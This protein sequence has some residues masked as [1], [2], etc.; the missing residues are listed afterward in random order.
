MAS[1][2]VV[3]DEGS[4]CVVDGGSQ[5]NTERYARDEAQLEL[6]RAV[7]RGDLAT[8]Q[9]TLERGASVSLMDRFGQC[10]FVIVFSITMYVVVVC[11]QH[12]TTHCC[13]VGT[14]R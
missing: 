11:R 2:Y 4:E 6:H 9:E 5:P 1:R 7:F 14:Q 12:S 8:T 3:E 10:L 13:H